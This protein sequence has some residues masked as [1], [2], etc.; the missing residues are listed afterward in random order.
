MY[1]IYDDPAELLLLAKERDVDLSVP[2]GLAIATGAGGR[3][4]D[5]DSARRAIAAGLG[6]A[7]V[8]PVGTQPARHLP[9]IAPSASVP[10][11]NAALRR[12]RPVVN[13]AG[14]TLFTAGP[15]APLGTDRSLERHFRLLLRGALVAPA[16]SSRPAILDLANVDY[17]W[18]LTRASVED[19]A[20]F[21]RATL[22]PVTDTPKGGELLDLLDVLYE[23]RDGYTGA[24]NALDVHRNTVDARRKRL[25]DLTGLSLEVP[26]DAHRLFTA[27]R[28]L[29][30]LAAPST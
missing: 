4:V 13:S 8:G 3:D 6:G 30:L 10:E 14:L 15:F 22:G 21:V 20:D 27:S 1:G 29:R 28:L 11:W 18:L 25:T 24:A 7:L 16:A 19:R 12:L 26:G 9:F 23:T 2:H 17:H 5:L